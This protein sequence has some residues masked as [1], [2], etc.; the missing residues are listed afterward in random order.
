MKPTVI[1]S[2]YPDKKSITKIAKMFVKNKTAACVNISKISSIYSW[3]KKI[4]NTSEY[5]A[6][7]KTT[8]KNTKLLKEKIKETHPYDVPEIAEIDVTS[9]NKSY[10]DWLIDS[11]S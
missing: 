1:I 8:S 9:I 7:F 3:N 10:L 5:I 6:I 11:T 4:E 2:T